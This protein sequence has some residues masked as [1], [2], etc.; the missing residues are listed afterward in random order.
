MGG[1]RK[2]YTKFLSENLKGKERGR[3]RHRWENN[4]TI[5]LRDI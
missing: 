3:P 4:I 5:D 2:L 1:M